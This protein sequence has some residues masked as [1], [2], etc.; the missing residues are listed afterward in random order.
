MGDSTAPN[1]AK[2]EQ[3]DSSRKVFIVTY[4]LPVK[5]SKNALTSEWSVTWAEDDFI[6]RSPSS[7]ADALDT[8]W[9]G[10]VTKACLD[11]ATL[12]LL[13]DIPSPHLSLSHVESSIDSD[14]SSSIAGY[15]SSVVKDFGIDR[16]NETLSTT[17]LRESNSKSYVGPDGVTISPDTFT[18]S[19][20]PTDMAA[21]TNVLGELNVVPVFLPLDLHEGF[22]AFCQAVIKPAFHNV[23]ETGSQKIFPFASSLSYLSS[24]WEEYK[25]ANEAFA[26]AV[27]SLYKKDDIV[28]IHDL[29]LCVVPEVVARSVIAAFGSRPPMIF[30]MHAPFPT[31]EIFRTIPVREELLRGILGC[32]VIGFH[33]F[34]YARHFLQSVK[35]L[36]NFNLT[37]RGLGSL[38][39][40]VEGRDVMVSISHVG[41]EPTVL[42]SA[43]ETHQA[44]EF[45]SGIMAKYPGKTIIAGID[46]C[47]RLSGVALK[48]LAFERLLEENPV[49][50]QKVVLVQRCTIAQAL[51][52]DIKKTSSEL[53]ERVAKIK[54]THGDVI[55]YEEVRTFPL[56]SRIGLYHCADILLQTPIREGLSLLPL[57]Y[58]FVRTQWEN[59]RVGVTG[60][61]PIPNKDSLIQES[62]LPP[63]HYA[64][65]SASNSIRSSHLQRVSL[66]SSFLV[67]TS[68]NPSVFTGNNMGA[69]SKVLSP[70]SRGGCLV[71]SEFSTASHMLNSNLQV[72]PWNISSVAKEI[73]IALQMP[74]KERS[75]RQWRDYQYVIRNPS[76]QWSLQ[77]ISDVLEV[78]SGAKVS[79]FNKQPPLPPLDLSSL[80]A[81]MATS[82]KRLFILDYG[83]SIMDR[84]AKSRRDFTIDGYS[85][86]LPQYVV[87][88]LEKISLD[89]RNTI[90]IVSGLSSSS[91]TSL[92]FANIQRLHIASENGMFVSHIDSSG[93][94]V[95]NLLNERLNPELEEWQVLK[96]KVIAKMVEY[97]TKVNGSVVRKYDTL[98]AWEFKHADPD[99]GSKQAAYLAEEISAVASRKVQVSVSKTRVE[100]SITSANKGTFINE[101]LS[102]AMWTKSSST[103]I[104]IVGDD[105]TDEHMYREAHRW[106]NA[107][108]T[109]D[110]QRVKLFTVTV[111]RFDKVSEARAVIPSVKATQDLL[112]RLAAI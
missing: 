72:N 84:D 102:D 63:Q 95:W 73:D 40:D 60:I 15:S 5:L 81:S 3:F 68:S 1:R 16:P 69:N 44:Y 13:A 105:T 109:P 32:D 74:A 34:N 43:M 33:T 47:Q 57:E 76:A 87:D 75:F 51:V 6:A 20:S 108:S 52:S 29:Q 107:L 104:L 58:V 61:D 4:S 37:R 49:Y 54:A 92:Q 79:D 46:S 99:W 27:L 31:S 21:I 86:H 50:R 10:A 56:S 28:W 17:L 14:F 67:K 25:L 22:V 2:S 71:L 112:Q 39:I 110:Q 94:R 53:R 85:K 80:E 78:N 90:Y 42:A 19:F 48:L 106:H 9:V 97:Q 59:K 41:I 82:E 88:A 55:D 8:I 62:D 36:L 12:D 30:F 98:V 96:Q 38:A 101:V 18:I 100:A 91:L 77:M 93:T 26:K 11:D 66:P 89:P 7:L 24:G 70:P 83:G 23:L 111:G 45:A 65:Y 35:R 64:T 103:S